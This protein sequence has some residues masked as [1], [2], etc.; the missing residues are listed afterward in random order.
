MSNIR[1]EV[2]SL[3]DLGTR[4]SIF[5]NIK[6]LLTEYLMNNTLNISNSTFSI[7]QL[8]IDLIDSSYTL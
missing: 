6:L 1:A 7:K 3:K 8:N 5:V 2:E 4:V